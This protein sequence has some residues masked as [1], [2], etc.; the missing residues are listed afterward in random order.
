MFIQNLIIILLA[1]N[2]V[3][4]ST[5]QMSKPRLIEAV[6]LAYVTQLIND[7]TGI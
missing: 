3:I 5:L 1:T 4:I 6:V 2:N 7:R